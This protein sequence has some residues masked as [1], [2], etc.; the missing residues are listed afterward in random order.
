MNVQAVLDDLESYER[1]LARPLL[2]ARLT[3]RRLEGREF[4]FGPYVA[5]AL[6]LWLYGP[7]VVG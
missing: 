3:G 7:V 4:H 6:W 1:A 5:G 2:A